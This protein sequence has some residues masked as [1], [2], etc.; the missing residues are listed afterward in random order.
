MSEHWQSFRR[1][2]ATLR[3][4]TLRTLWR[5]VD[6]TAAR[7]ILRRFFA[8][9]PSTPRELVVRINP[10]SSEGGQDDLL[11]AI[12]CEPDGILLPKIATP[13]DILEAGDV[14]DENDAP[15]EPQAVGHDRNAAR[16]DEYRRTSPNLAV[17]RLRGSIVSLREPMI[18]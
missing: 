9:R 1:L 13:R 7:E 3:S 8:K 16:A 6:K 15:D 2:L 10:L 11:A 4:S 18:W 14:L 12:A 5:S 17:I